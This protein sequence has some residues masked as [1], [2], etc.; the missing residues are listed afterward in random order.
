VRQY[1]HGLATNDFDYYAMPLEAM[2]YGLQ[3][4]FESDPTAAFPVADK[5]R[6]ELAIT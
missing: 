3:R 4:R 2:A 1:V 6:R 5:V